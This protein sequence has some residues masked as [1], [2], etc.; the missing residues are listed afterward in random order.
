[1]KHKKIKRKKKNRAIR[2]TDWALSAKFRSYYG[3][4]AK[5]KSCLKQLTR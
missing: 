1:M 3:C 2:M 4:K 5:L